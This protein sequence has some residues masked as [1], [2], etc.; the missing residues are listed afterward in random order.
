MLVTQSCPTLCNPTDCSPPGF[1]VHGIFQARILEWV[2]ISFSRGSSKPQKL[3]LGLPHCKQTLYCLSHQGSYPGLKPTSPTLGAHSLPSEPPGK[4]K[5]TG[6]GSLS[7]LQGI[8]PTQELNWDLLHCRWILYQLSYQE[9][10]I[11]TRVLC[12]YTF[13][14]SLLW[15]WTLICYLITWPKERKKV[16]SLSRVRLFVTPWMVAYQ[17]PQS[18]GFSRQ[19]YWSGL[20]LSFP[21]DLP[22]P[23]IEP[24]SPTLQS[25]ALPSEPPGKPNLTK[26]LLKNHM[27]FKF[28]TH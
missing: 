20:P 7:I 14:Q 27:L 15:T 16:K 19:E 5:N 3:N 26:F 23:W 22:D 11:K 1:S 24:G 9:S 18:M 12:K 6:V 4:P 8:F 13:Q 17:A 28:T 10:P 2:A 25:D 21:G